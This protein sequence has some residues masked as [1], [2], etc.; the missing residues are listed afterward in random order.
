[1]TCNG[2]TISSQQLEKKVASFIIERGRKHVISVKADRHTSYEAYFAMQNAIVNAYS[3]VRDMMARRDYNTPYARCSQQ[4]RDE[5][6]KKCP[7]RISEAEPTSG[8][9]DN[10]GDD[11]AD[12]GKGGKR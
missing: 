3:D 12:S 11:L 7:Q 4:Q 9:G 2:D 6:A 10:S 8:E 1:M 5:I